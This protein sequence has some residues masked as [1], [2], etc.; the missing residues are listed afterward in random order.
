VTLDMVVTD[1]RCANVAART[2]RLLGLLEPTCVRGRV[3]TFVDVS[4]RDADEVVKALWGTDG[5][6]VAVEPLDEEA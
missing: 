5:E 2:L 3:L 6:V 1:H 4:A